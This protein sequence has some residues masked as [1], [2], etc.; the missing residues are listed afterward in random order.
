M[1]CNM[2]P[3]DYTV[4]NRAMVELILG[5]GNLWKADGFWNCRSH[6]LQWWSA[7]SLQCIQ[8]DRRWNAEKPSATLDP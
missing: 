8:Q 6:I 5:R 7:A 2:S 3:Y 4:I 1:L